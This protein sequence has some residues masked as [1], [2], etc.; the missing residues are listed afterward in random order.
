M[1][2]RPTLAGIKSSLMKWRGQPHGEANHGAH[3]KPYNYVHMYT[4]GRP[5]RHHLSMFKT[6]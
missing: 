6:S 3:A 2:I 5:G 4:P 1:A